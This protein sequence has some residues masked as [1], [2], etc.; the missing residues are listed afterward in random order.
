M[1]TMC[2]IVYVKYTNLYIAE[3]SVYIYL[4]EE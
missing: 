1:H 4:R 3:D 2:H